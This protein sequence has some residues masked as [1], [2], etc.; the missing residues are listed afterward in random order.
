MLFR[1]IDSAETKYSNALAYFNSRIPNGSDLL[2]Q[3]KIDFGITKDALLINNQCNNS[4]NT[5]PPIASS[6]T[7]D[8]DY[9]AGTIGY[10]SSYDTATSSTNAGSKGY[11]NISIVRND[12]IEI[13]QEFVIP[14][15]IQGPIIQ[16]LGM[17]TSKTISINIDG[18]SPDNKEC[19]SFCD[20]DGGFDPC[21]SLPNFSIE[22]FDKLLETN[23]GWI[24]TKEDYTSNKLDGSYSISLEYTCKG[25]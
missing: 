16:R 24:K 14:G 12:P 11:S 9:T 6:F 2:P 23:E 5:D 1:S 13:I 4:N 20:G 22:N 25:Q 10:S 19:I 21:N 8:H 18:A 3:R 7:V 17:K 15:R